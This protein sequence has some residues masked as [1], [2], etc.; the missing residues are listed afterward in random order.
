M[1][2]HMPSLYSYAPSLISEQG[3]LVVRASTSPL[4]HHLYNYKYIYN[5][6]PFLISDQGVPVLA[7]I[8]DGWILVEISDGWISV[9]AG[10]Q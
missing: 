2:N 10:D 1:H 9:M 7:D 6:T 4:T 5:Y 8:S 3:V